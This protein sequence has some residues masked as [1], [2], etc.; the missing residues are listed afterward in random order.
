MKYVALVLLVDSLSRA[1]GAVTDP[2]CSQCGEDQVCCYNRCVSASSC[3]GHFCI[4][5]NHC[6]SDE[7]CCNAECTYSRCTGHECVTKSKCGSGRGPTSS[8]GND[9]Y[10]STAA[11][12]IIGGLILGALVI[13]CIAILC[14]RSYCHRRTAVSTTVTIARETQSDRQYQGEQ[15]PPPYLEGPPPQYQQQQT[16]IRPPFN[17]GTLAVIEPPPPYTA[18]PQERSQGYTPQP[19][20]GA[21]PSTPAV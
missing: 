21:I 12:G 19:S 2:R 13:V 6:S 20:Y 7:I 16:M 11:L 3:L 8:P 4:T 1:L 10:D 18:V 17:P 9:A 14:I 15:P 5:D